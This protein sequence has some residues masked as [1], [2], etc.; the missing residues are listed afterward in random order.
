MHVEQIGSAT[1]YLGDCMELMA[2]MPDKSIDLA[3]V[4]P[5][6][7]KNAGCSGIKKT[8]KQMKI[9]NDIPPDAK[10]FQQLFRVSK[11]QIIFGGNL[12]NEVPIPKGGFV[13]WD[14]N[15]HFKI[16]SDGELIWVSGENKIKKYTFDMGYSRGFDYKN[17]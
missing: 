10:Y 13:F 9:Y 4:D 2:T 14:K 12:F 15:M 3:I 7:G 8:K 5:P 11:K 1:L 17:R 6:W 16:F